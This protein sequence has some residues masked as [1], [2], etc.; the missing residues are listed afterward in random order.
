MEGQRDTITSVV[1]SCNETPCPSRRDAGTQGAFADETKN[2][3]KG[4]LTM[5]KNG[6]YRHPVSGIDENGCPY[7]CG[8][9]LPYPE[10]EDDELLDDMSPLEQEIVLLWISERLSPRKTVNDRHTSYGLKH[11]LEHDTG[12]YM[13]NNTFKDAMIRCGYAPHDEH[14]LNWEYAISQRSPC[15]RLDEYRRHERAWLAE[16]APD[17]ARKLREEYDERSR[18]LEER[19]NLSGNNVEG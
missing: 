4:W 1:N 17:L 13:T 2:T 5:M 14:E 9:M 15:F 10:G 3:E 19:R 11:C 12:V 16:R 18:K 7:S 6:K 8:G